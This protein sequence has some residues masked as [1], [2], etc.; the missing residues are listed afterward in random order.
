MCT[1]VYLINRLPT[2]I[3]KIRSPYHLVYNQEPDYNL[4]KSFGCT[5]Y[6]SLRSYT[7]S[8]LDSRSKRCVFLGYSVF[9]SGYRC[10]SLTSG[11]LYISRDVIIIENTYP[12]KEQSQQTQI[13]N[14]NS[15]IALG[16]LGSSPTTIKPTYTSQ[17]ISSSN[18]SSFKHSSLMT[19]K[20]C[21][22]S[23]IMHGSHSP[24]QKSPTRNSPDSSTTC[25]IPSTDPLSPS[26]MDSYNTKSHVKTRRLS[27]TFRTIDSANG[28]HTTKFPLPTC[29]HISSYV[30]PKPINFS[31]VVKQLE[32]EAAMKDE[33]QALM[34]NNTWKL[35]PRPH[36]HPVIG[37]KWIYKTKPSADGTPPKY[38]AH[39]VAKGFLQEGGIDYHETFSPIIKVTTIR[40][41]LSLA[42]SQKWHI[43]QL[44][45]S[46]AF[47]HIDLHELIYMDQPQGFQNQQYPHHVCQLQK[48]LYGLKQS[49]G[50]WF[51]KLTNRLLQLG[52]QGSKT[53]T[54]L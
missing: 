19:S 11:K 32:W 18:T 16:L 51:Q 44:D 35:V 53:N 40:L 33:F 7:T 1:T 2:K 12:Y 27:D 54:S 5:C 52:F 28:T 46:N 22:I 38:K 39:L 25:H 9:H 10:L 4:L 42:I 6:P 34:H 31:S 41:L 50:E 37:C 14:S 43:R 45:I 13:S 49:P 26:N 48:S 23:P 17:A 24:L 30:F 29:L 15:Q 36:K 20:Q 3:L 47:L 8:K 21:Q